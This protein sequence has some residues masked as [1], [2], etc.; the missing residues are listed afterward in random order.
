MQ[1]D[2]DIQPK[3]SILDCFVRLF[4]SATTCIANNLSFDLRLPGFFIERQ[5]ERILK[6]RGRTTTNGPFTS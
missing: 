6:S 3:I 4:E 1:K 5:P 2:T